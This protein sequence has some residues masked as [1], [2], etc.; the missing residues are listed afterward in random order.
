MSYSEI[1][2]II[3]QD[4]TRGMSN[5]YENIEKGF[6]QRSTDLIL[7][8]K[9]VV[10][11]TTGFFILSAKSSETDGPPG[12]IALGNALE[13]LGYD[14]LFITDKYS[15]GILVGMSDEK[16]V[17]EFPVTTHFESNSYANELIKKYDPK[18]I[19]S[20]ERAGLSK[21]GK[22]RNFKGID[23]SKFNAKVDY[24]FEQHPNTIGILDGGNEIGSGNYINEIETLGNII[25]YPSIITTSESIIS[26]TSNWG[27][28]GLI[29]GISIHQKINLLPSVDEGKKLIEKSFNLGA[30]EGMSGE[31]KPWV[32]GR[33]IEEDKVCLEKLNSL[34]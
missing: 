26:S 22:Y 13:K 11:I 9:G 3:L 24:L 8:K 27:A 4:D 34:I 31:S 18:S 30:V 7:K 1:E 16:K 25:E 15:S 32:D 17:I 5:L 6:I 14:V 33:S 2:K 28:Y 20:I 19:I 23:F 21:D 10:F 29:A 12:A